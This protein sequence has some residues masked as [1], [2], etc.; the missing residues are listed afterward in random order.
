LDQTGGDLTFTTGSA[1]FNLGVSPDK[2]KVTIKGTV[3]TMDG[4]EIASSAATAYFFYF[5]TDP[6]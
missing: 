2:Y 6:C 5:L 4:G 3:K 1:M